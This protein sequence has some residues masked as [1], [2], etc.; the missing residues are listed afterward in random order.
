MTSR[1]KIKI[2]NILFVGILISC[3]LILILHGT[4]NTI[5]FF[6]KPSDLQNLPLPSGNIRL[7]GFVKSGSISYTDVNSVSFILT[8]H[9]SHLQVYY[10][11]LIPTL[12]RDSQGVVV[13]GILQSD[14]NFIATEM[15]AKHDENYRPPGLDS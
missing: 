6:Y 14:G 4:S 8:D 13:K 15:L 11:G 1:A 7:G 3:G 5:T 10:N 12:F 2:F 9:K